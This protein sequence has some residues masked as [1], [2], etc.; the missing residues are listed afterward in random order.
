M[1]LSNP[2][3]DLGLGDLGLHC[4]PMYPT[5]MNSHPV[6][7][8]YLTS[9]SAVSHQY[10]SSISPVSQQYLARISPVSGSPL[11]TVLGFT[12]VEFAALE[13]AVLGSAVS[14]TA[15]VGLTAFGRMGRFHGLWPNG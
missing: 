15:W 7:H 6:S 9:I 1:I 5:S 4:H 12:A 13:L 10:L 2:I 14:A 11:G 3:P 8:Q